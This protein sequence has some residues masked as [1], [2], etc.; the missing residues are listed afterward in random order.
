MHPPSP[1]ADNFYS[2]TIILTWT[3]NK[4]V[5]SIVGGSESEDPLYLLANK[6]QSLK[7]YV[8][9]ATDNRRKL[10]NSLK[11]NYLYVTTLPGISI[12]HGLLKNTFYKLWNKNMYNQYKL[13]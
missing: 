8:M 11:S 7:Q 6:T 1:H 4:A 2:Q 10:T 12:F 9:S 5:S 13:F 3:L